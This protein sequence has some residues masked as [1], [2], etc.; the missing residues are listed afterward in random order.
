MRTRLGYQR[1]IGCGGEA[2]EKHGSTRRW[3]RVLVVDDDA[4]VQRGMSDYLEQHNM[5]VVS[6]RHRQDVTRQ[7]ATT[8]LDFVLLD[9]R[10]NE[11]DGLDVLREIRLRSTVPVIIMAGERS[12]ETDRVVA[13]ELGADAYLTEPFGL[14]ELLARIQAML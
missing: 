8:E 9:L 10:L 12:E 7:L 13:L 1:T 6:A 3:L 5:R 11:E 4:S 2:V 14:R